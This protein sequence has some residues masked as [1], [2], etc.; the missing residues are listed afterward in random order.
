MPHEW[1]FSL[2]T[3]VIVIPQY[4][5]HCLLTSVYDSK[6]VEQAIELNA[7]TAVEYEQKDDT[8]DVRF[9]CDEK[10]CWTPVIGK[11][12]RHTVPTRLFSLRAPPHVHARLPSSGSSTGEASDSN[13]SLHV[14]AGVVCYPSH[15]GKPGLQVT[16]TALKKLDSHFI[17]VL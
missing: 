4:V 14:P 9:I 16:P 7:H 12:S 3:R 2:L 8:L 13:C 5:P 6:S 17:L 11:R 15:S 10:E 1:N